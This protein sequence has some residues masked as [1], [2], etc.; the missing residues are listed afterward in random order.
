MYLSFYNL[1]SSHNLLF[2]TFQI[3]FSNHNPKLSKY[4]FILLKHFH[5]LCFTLETI[6]TIITN[7]KETSKSC[8]AL[9]DIR[10][11]ENRKLTQTRL[12][13]IK[14]NRTFPNLKPFILNFNSI[15]NKPQKSPITFGTRPVPYLL[16][17]HPIPLN[18][19]KLIPN[20][21]KSLDHPSWSHPYI[22]GGSL[23]S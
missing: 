11:F 10:K 8:I 17:L 13:C 7:L 1:Y 4:G 23:E 18:Y 15:I 16:K 12:F 6:K 14:S 2:L 22:R 20:L 5:I 19:Y 21:P 3:Q 9:A